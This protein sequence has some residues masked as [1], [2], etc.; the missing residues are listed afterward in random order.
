MGVQW[1]RKPGSKRRPFRRLAARDPLPRK[2]PFSGLVRTGI[3][4]PGSVIWTALTA[5]DAE[6]TDADHA[7]LAWLTILPVTLPPPEAA[8]RLLRRYVPRLTRFDPGTERLL[9]L[10]VLVSRYGRWCHPACDRN[11]QPEE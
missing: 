4:D 11:Y 5:V 7:V 8:A 3:E 2:R 9:E 10:L 6:R 1:A